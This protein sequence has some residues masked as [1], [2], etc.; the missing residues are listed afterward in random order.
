MPGQYLS[1]SCAPFCSSSFLCSFKNSSISHSW[2]HSGSWLGPRGSSPACQSSSCPGVQSCPHGFNHFFSLLWLHTVLRCYLCRRILMVF[3]LKWLIGLLLVR[4]KT[5]SKSP[6]VS[7]SFSWLESSLSL[8]EFLKVALLN[9]PLSSGFLKSWKKLNALTNSSPDS[10]CWF[11]F[12]CCSVSVLNVVIWLL[13][14]TVVSSGVILLIFSS[15]LLT[16]TFLCLKG[17]VLG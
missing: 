6:S 15:N 9:F 8:S 2:S 5:S 3:L 11:C 12:H 14:V 1:C 13:H 7:S 10:W 4:W 16:C 17:I